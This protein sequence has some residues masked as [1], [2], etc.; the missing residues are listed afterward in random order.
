MVITIP[1]R[2]SGPP[3]S[4]NGGYTAGLFAETM[5]SAGADIIQGAEITLRK[6]IPLETPMCVKA[7]N[8][9]FQLISTE[10]IAEGKLVT[11][12]LAVRCLLPVRAGEKC[13]LLSWRLGIDGRKHRAAAA[14]LNEHGES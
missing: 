3:D 5:H 11:G 12:R 1:S 10:L 14:L 4:G 8:D 13:V 7:H 9:N 2:F 6:P